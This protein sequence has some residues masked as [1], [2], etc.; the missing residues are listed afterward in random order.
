[1]ALDSA[2]FFLG[3]LPTFFKAARIGAFVIASS[4]ASS[5]AM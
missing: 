2:S 3:I 5:A 1:L 4:L